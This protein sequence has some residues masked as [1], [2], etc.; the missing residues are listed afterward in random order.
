MHVL[1]L[2]GDA[3]DGDEVQDAL[4]QVTGS[5]TVPQVFV[6]SKY[7]GGCDGEP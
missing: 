7:I 2:Y 6:G 3:A 5:R 1:N 4:M